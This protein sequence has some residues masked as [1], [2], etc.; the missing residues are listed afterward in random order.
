M[1]QTP[2]AK[3]V[4]FNDIK[5]SVNCQHTLTWKLQEPS[6]TLRS[7]SCHWW[8]LLDSMLVSCFLRMLNVRFKRSIAF[9]QSAS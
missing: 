5:Q 3:L 9:A 8:G 2:D 4:L 6:R 1:T 7:S